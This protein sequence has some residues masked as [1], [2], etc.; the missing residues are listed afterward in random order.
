[1]L[2]HPSFNV[3]A[4]HADESGGDTAR[5]SP[6]AAP[7]GDPVDPSQKERGVAMTI[8]SQPLVASEGYEALKA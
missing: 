6:D 5:A 2:M 4:V 1:M 7:L 8:D 3:Q